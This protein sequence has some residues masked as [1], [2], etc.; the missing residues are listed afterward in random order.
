MIGDQ[1]PDIGAAT[2]DDSLL[3][4]LSIDISTFGLALVTGGSAV[5]SL[6][7]AA[8]MTEEEEKEEE[9]REL[10]ETIL[11][12]RITENSEPKDDAPDTN[13]DADVGGNSTDDALARDRMK[14]VWDK[15]DLK[16][17]E[18]ANKNKAKQRKLDAEKK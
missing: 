6:A 9:G 15:K 13:S 1:A 8:E 7:K 4:E 2:P 16:K 12:N 3:W 14:K 17:F 10:G 5:Y 11:E 18:E